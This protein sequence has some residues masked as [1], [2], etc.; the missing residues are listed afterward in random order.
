MFNNNNMAEE[1]YA[2]QQ[3]QTREKYVIA[4]ASEV[5]KV[6]I[7]GFPEGGLYLMLDPKYKSFKEI[8]INT[9]N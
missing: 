1:T 4:G 7:R 3:T 9:Y 2:V 5:K 6:Q 8:P